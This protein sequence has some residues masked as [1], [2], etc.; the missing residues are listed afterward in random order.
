M[1]YNI[2]VTFICF[3]QYYSIMLHY[4]YLIWLGLNLCI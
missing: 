1:Y 2:K 4:Y 3:S